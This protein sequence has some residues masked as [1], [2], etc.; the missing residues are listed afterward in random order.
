MSDEINRNF[1]PAISPERSIQA[2]LLLLLGQKPSHGYEV[3]QRLNEANFQSGEADA[4]TV[5]RNLRRLDK[6]GFIKS[7]WEV[8]ESSPERRQYELTP[9]GQ[10][11]LRLWSQYLIQ[12]KN[13]LEN[14]LQAY[15][16]YEKSL[17][18]KDGVKQ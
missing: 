16:D 5:Y 8:G 6:D 18:K 12:Q 9:Q 1:E 15:D 11:L 14:F 7:H 10:E 2:E 13:R 17:L 4:A 3:I